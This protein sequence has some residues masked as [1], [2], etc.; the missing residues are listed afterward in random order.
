MSYSTRIDGSVR[1]TPPLTWKQIK[2]SPL[3]RDNFGKAR[4]W[5]DAHLVVDEAIVHTDDGQLARRTCER[6]DPMEETR[7]DTLV[8]DLQA[9]IDANPEHEFVGQFEC[10]GEEPGDI[11][12]AVIRGRIAVRVEPRIVWPDDADA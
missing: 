3:L 4:G 12:R 1:I 6:I 10:F 2:D 9:V 7:G 11:W 5:P 8:A